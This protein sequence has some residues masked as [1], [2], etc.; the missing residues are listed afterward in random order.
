MML[1]RLDNPS[2]AETGNL[3]R[4]ETASLM[5]DPDPEPRYVVALDF[6]F[7]GRKDVALDLLKSAIGTGRYCAYDGLRNDSAFEGLRGT[8]EF[9]Q[10]LSAA[11]QCKDK[12]L[13]ERMQSPH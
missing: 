8:S 13:A 12:F 11:K 9:N 5:A 7:C 3:V 6:E 1:A 10:I 2:S 4:Q